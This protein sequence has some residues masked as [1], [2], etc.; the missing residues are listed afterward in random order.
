MSNDKSL[1]IDLAECLEGQH[2]PG[3]R[4]AAAAEL[5]RLDAVN[6]ELLDVLRLADEALELE[7][8]H[9]SGHTRAAIFKAIAKA[10]SND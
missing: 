2:A 10:T 4:A 3:L 5:R 1:A 6:R 7:G 9:T 8:F